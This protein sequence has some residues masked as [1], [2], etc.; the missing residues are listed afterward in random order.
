MKKILLMACVSMIAVACG[1]NK[2]Q[3]VLVLYYS[4]NGTTKVVA[5]EI[6]NRLNADVEAIVPINPYNGSYQETIE[7]GKVEK[8][9][10]FLPDIQPLKAN[11]KDYDVIFLGYPIWFG[12]YPQPVA[13]LLSTNDFNGKKVVP[14]CTFGS[15]GLDSSIKDL[16]A[17]LPNSE[18]F[19]GYGVRAA[20]ISAMPAELDRFLKENGFVKGECEKLADFSDAHAVTADESDIFDSAVA[21]Y[22]MIHAKAE[23]V[24]S[25]SV[26]NGVEYLFVARELPREEATEDV[27]TRTF[28][29]YVL[30]ENGKSPVFTQVVR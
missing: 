6:G 16:K 2:S 29:V 15:G 21:G 24:S 20:R 12:T 19:P 18:I 1:Q 13:T 9:S 23:E 8:D 4:Q 17:S 27:P 26:P 10:N 14:F 28:K 11:V 30:V 22:K 25:R 3:K 7:R 5:D